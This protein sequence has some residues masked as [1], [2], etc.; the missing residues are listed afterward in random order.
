MPTYEHTKT[1]VSARPT[2]RNSDGLVKAW[3]IEV[4]YSYAGD[5]ANS[6]PE[7]SK[8][9][10]HSWEIEEPS[11]VP[12]G[13]TKAELVAEMP[14]VISD[15]IFGAHYEAFNIPAVSEDETVDD[16]DLNSLS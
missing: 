2:V 6:L 7:W 15:H 4:E 8:G 5:E 1:L 9:Y 11:K 10:S 3:E 16:F 12:S 13:Y 14:A